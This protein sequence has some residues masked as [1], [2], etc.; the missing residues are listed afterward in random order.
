M[1]AHTRYVP[2]TS[3]RLIGAG[4]VCAAV[5]L[6]VLVGWHSG[7]P[8]L[9][10]IGAGWRSMAYNIALGLL[11]C[12]IGIISLALHRRRLLTL[13]SGLTAA[14][15]AGL[16]FGEHVF[17][18]DLRI[19]QFLAD[20]HIPQPA[21]LPVRGELESALCLVVSGLAIALLGAFHRSRYTPLV[22]G[23]AGTITTSLG[24]LSLLANLVGFTWF[25]AGGRLAPMALLTGLGFS[26]LGVALLLLARENVGI[27]PQRPRWAPILVE[28]GVLAVTF[29]LAHAMAFERQ[30]WISSAVT[31]ETEHLR[32]AVAAEVADQVLALERLAKIWQLWID[33][34]EGKW[35]P[36]AEVYVK[37][38]PGLE[39]ISWID[40]SSRVRR[41]TPQKGK[42]TGLNSNI[43]RDPARYEALLAALR[44]RTTALTRS[45]EITPGNWAVEAYVPV[46]AANGPRGFVRG[47]FLV[48]PLMESILQAPVAA[49][50]SLAISEGDHRIY[51]RNLDPDRSAALGLNW[52]AEA[53]LKLY[54]VPWRIE[55]WP[56]SAGLEAMTSRFPE[57]TLA[58]GL[59]AAIILGITAY[60]AQGYNERAKEAEMARKD[61]EDAMAV[62][63]EAESRLAESARELQG[64]NEELAR[65][66]TTAKEATELKSRFLATMS[67]EIRTPMNGVLGMTDLLLDTTLTAEQREYGA[68]VKDSADSLLRIIDDI[69]DLSKIEAGKVEFESIPFDPVATAGSVAGMLY[70]RAREKNLKLACQFGPDVPRF[71]RG[72]PF[73]FRQVLTNLIANSIKFTD[74]GGITVCGEAL[75]QTD[76]SVTLRF[77]VEDTGVGIPQD[78][79]PEIFESFTQADSSTTRRYGGTGLG[80]AIS[81]Q[82]VEMLGGKI[83]CESEVGRGSRF[84]F[85]LPFGRA[86]AE[87]LVAP[88][89]VSRP[90]PAPTNEQPRETKRILVVEDN[91]VNQTVA[92]RL[93]ANAGHSAEAVSN[94]RQALAAIEQASYDLVF[95]DVQM[96][97]MDGFETTASIR[98]LEGVTRHTPI[99]AMTASAME[100]DR[101]KCLNYGM[102][103]YICKPISAVAIREVLARWFPVADCAGD[104]AP[105][106]V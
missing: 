73:R 27:S 70:P 44:G 91:R 8:A 58:V 90:S 64:K 29:S 99:V 22:V 31:L 32:T 7:S 67:H 68:A 62:R 74:T 38:Y 39:M 79:L 46:F 43:T 77:S 81:K 14:A 6:I 21:W 93:L 75:D 102:D 35:E 97:E 24:F 3:I 87:E 61:L 10:R 41:V 13:L 45:I 92:L 34:P 78:K 12:G 48:R 49:G 88:A 94:G 5:G 20:Y 89:P 11:A 28:S 65:A 30:T 50:Y 82:I 25:Y 84:I 106:G 15:M 19:G 104:R 96:P 56:T 54:G 76:H 55:V 18:I 85:S 9:T 52:R 2:N 86:S 80:L 103:D 33:V 51:E 16:T 95:M 72:D 69:L 98:L 100:G 23:L 63:R 60:L 40:S 53:T 57:V 83:A 37:H 71:V 66:L 17:G 42:E 4:G 1:A 26:V 47:T 105:T 59:L 101:E 36:L